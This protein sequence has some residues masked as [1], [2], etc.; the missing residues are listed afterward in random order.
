M[1]LSRGRTRSHLKPWS[2]T[3]DAGHLAIAQGSAG[4]SVLS[5]TGSSGLL[6]GCKDMN[7]WITQAQ[8]QQ[9]GGVGLCITPKTQATAVPNPGPLSSTCKSQVDKYSCLSHHLLKIKTNYC[10]QGQWHTEYHSYSKKGL[11]YCP[12]VC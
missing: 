7:H 12:A 6:E 10:M 9:W 8:T 1:H 3:T 4:Y 2:H 5:L 11:F